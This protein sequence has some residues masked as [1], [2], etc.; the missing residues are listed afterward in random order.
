MKFPEGYMPKIGDKLIHLHGQP[1]SVYEIETLYPIDRN[2]FKVKYLEV[3]SNSPNLDNSTTKLWLG[4][5]NF[6]GL[7]DKEEKAP[8][9]IKQ[10]KGIK[11][12]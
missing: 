9:T 4:T 2:Y 3:L 10:F 7:Y 8:M 12:V 6:K 11:N 5:H 1:N